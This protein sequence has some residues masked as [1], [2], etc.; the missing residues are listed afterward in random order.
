VF[1]Y[2]YKNNTQKVYDYKV[3][4]TLLYLTSSVVLDP[5][6]M[7]KIDVKPMI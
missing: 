6:L 4:S 5:D 7:E 1:H 2:K 3:R